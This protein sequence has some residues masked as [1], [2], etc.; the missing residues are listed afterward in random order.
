M[1]KE[2]N[3]FHQLFSI[4]S[5]KHKNYY[6]LYIFIL[7]LASILQVLGIGSIIPLTTAFFNNTAEIAVVNNIKEILNIGDNISSF[8]IILIFTTSTIIISNL[9]FLFF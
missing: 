1:L 6:Y 2:K 9:I 8:K 4:I 3:T 5:I 7:L